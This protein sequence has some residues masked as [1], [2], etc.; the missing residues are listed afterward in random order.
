MIGYGK[1]QIAYEN[2]F[3]VNSF[4]VAIRAKARQ[5]G[6]LLRRVADL[7]RPI[8]SLLGLFQRKRITTVGEEKHPARWYF[9]P[10]LEMNT[11]CSL[12]WICCRGAGVCAGTVMAGVSTNS[13]ATT[14]V[15]RRRMS[16]L[17]R[18]SEALR[19][20]TQLYGR[21]IEPSIVRNY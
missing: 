4:G 1:I 16:H 18:G 3:H 20:Q 19:M 6:L 9:L 10:V 12:F 8:A 2:I 15:T 11:V 13:R 5:I 7:A 14:V 17:L 21:F